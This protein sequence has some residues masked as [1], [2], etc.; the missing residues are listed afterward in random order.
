[1][2]GDFLET[3]RQTVGENEEKLQRFLKNVGENLENLPR[4][5]EISHEISKIS[6]V[7]EQGKNRE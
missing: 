5:L 2:L 4:F 3:W 1:L 6:D 7:L